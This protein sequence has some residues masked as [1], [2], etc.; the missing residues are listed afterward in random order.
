MEW[1]IYGCLLNNKKFQTYFTKEKSLHNFNFKQ[2]KYIFTV[3]KCL[4]F[5]YL[6]HYFNTIFINISFKE[7]ISQHRQHHA[8]SYI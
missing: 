1:E 3:N 8:P 7:N 4:K 2:R 6:W 5:I